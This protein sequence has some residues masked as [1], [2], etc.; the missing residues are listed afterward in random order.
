MRNWTREWNN[1]NTCNVL[2]SFVLFSFNSLANWREHVIIVGCCSGPNSAQHQFEGVLH[3]ICWDGWMAL[4]GWM[5]GSTM[6]VKKTRIAAARHTVFKIHRRNKLY[7]SIFD[8][9]YNFLF[10]TTDFYCGI[11]IGCFFHSEK[12][13]PYFLCGVVFVRTARRRL[14]I[15]VIL[16]NECY[17]LQIPRKI[18]VKFDA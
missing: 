5:C 8:D 17:D 6:V 15:A 13:C 11:A 3:G 16:T 2:K 7:L 4:W 1:I 12:L 18:W 9:D 10:I 14:W